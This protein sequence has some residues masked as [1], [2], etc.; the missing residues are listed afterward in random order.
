MIA[1]PYITTAVPIKYRGYIDLC[2]C[3]NPRQQSA[4]SN[5]IY[6]TA[7]Q[8]DHVSV[9]HSEKGIRDGK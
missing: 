6:N 5:V 4:L 7:N 3:I 8:S 2:M 9:I 1:A